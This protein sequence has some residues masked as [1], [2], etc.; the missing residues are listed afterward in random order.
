MLRDVLVVGGGP[1]GLF[2]AFRLSRHGYSVAVVE[3]HETAGKPVHCTGVLGLEAYE[4]FEIPREPILNQLQ[5]VRFVSPGEQSFVYKTAPVQAVVIDRHQFDH[6]LYLQACSAGVEFFLGKRVS[7]VQIDD[8]GATAICHGDSPPLRAKCLVLACGANYALQRQLGMGFPAAF[9]SSAQ[10][11]VPSSFQEGVELHFGRQVAP[12]GFA[13]SVPVYR[14]NANYSRFGLMCQGRSLYYFNNF[15]SRL[16]PR[17]GIADPL[18]VEPRLK[19][20]PLAPIRRTY[21]ERV[22]AIGDAAGLVKPTT[23]GGIYYSLLSAALASDVLAQALSRNDFSSKRLSAYERQWR[24]RLDSELRAQLALRKLAEKL[25]DQEIDAL[26]EL[27]RKD[28]L[29]PLIRKTA[30]FNYHRELI[31]ALFKHKQARSLLFKNLLS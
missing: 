20:L 23:G 19:V 4:E 21:N 3:E 8:S 27:A 15:I 14:G 5:Q 18:P 12:R 13:W 26:F 28:G 22:V 9:L 16:R 2:A 6:L 11:E 30:R 7:S 10:V 31:V 25:S 17:L 24:R 29:L 1:A